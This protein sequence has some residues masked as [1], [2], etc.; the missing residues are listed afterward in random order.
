MEGHENLPRFCFY[1]LSI[2]ESI[3][4]A[5]QS[6][7]RLSS[8][9]GRRWSHAARIDPRKSRNQ[10][11]GGEEGSETRK[12]KEKKRTPEDEGEDF[13][14]RALSSSDLKM[15]IFCGHSPRLLVIARQ[16]L[17][18]SSWEPRRCVQSFPCLL[19]RHRR[20]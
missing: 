16:L 19:A 6:S 9:D 14:L 17:L 20:V 11:K 12:K 13:A 1:P 4:R 2:G 15:D 8:A 7:P 3:D 10:G 18:S 5:R